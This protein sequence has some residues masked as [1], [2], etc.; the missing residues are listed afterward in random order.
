[1]LIV[2]RQTVDRVKGKIMSPATRL[3]SIQ[4]IKR[5]LEIKETLL[6]RADAGICCVQVGSALSTLL[7]REVDLLEK[8]LAALE[9]GD[10]AKA[11]SWLEDY[12]LL[13]ERDYGGCYSDYRQP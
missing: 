7:A 13:L 1:M 2:N 6:W 5:I 3:E 4:D 11:I 12:S 8:A 10:D 9:K